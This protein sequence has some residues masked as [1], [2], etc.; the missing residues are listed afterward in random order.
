MGIIVAAEWEVIIGDGPRIIC[1][2]RVEE[3]HNLLKNLQSPKFQKAK[4]EMKQY[5]E[6][7]ESRFLTFHIQK[8]EGYKSQRYQFVAG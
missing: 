5:V 2:G 6:N 1:E 8:V 4:K 7:Y 3:T